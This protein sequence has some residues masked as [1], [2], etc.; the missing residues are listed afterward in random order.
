MKDSILK[1]KTAGPSVW[2]NDSEQELKSEIKMSETNGEFWNILF[3]R[4]Q[5]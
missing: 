4:M 2:K 3:F 1:I 5:I